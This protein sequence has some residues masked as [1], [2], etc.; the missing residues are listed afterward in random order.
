M[1]LFPQRVLQDHTTTT[2]NTKNTYLNASLFRFGDSSHVPQGDLERET[3]DE[4]I[5]KPNTSG[6]SIL[7]DPNNWKNTT[8][9]NQH[10]IG[11]VQIAPQV[12]GTHGQ[13]GKPSPNP[14]QVTPTPGIALQM[15]N[16]E[17]WLKVT[18][19][20]DLV[21]NEDPFDL[22]P[23]LTGGRKT[24]FPIYYGNSKCRLT[25]TTNVFF[26]F[27]LGGVPLKKDFESR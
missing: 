8:T 13:T 11:G 2:V 25:I 18:I 24:V 19:N 14:H 6:K 12:Q 3:L 9:L 17:E 21:L 5:A 1:Y 22:D 26:L 15:T 16:E 10:K 20:Q 4:F 23:S 7:T 27:F